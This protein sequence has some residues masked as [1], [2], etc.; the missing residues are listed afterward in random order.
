MK[1][2][3]YITNSHPQYIESLYRDFVKD[4]AGVDPDLRKF[5]EGFDFA[6]GQNGSSNGAA[7]VTA[8]KPVD[9]GQLQKE[10]AVY[11]LIQAYR[12][13]AHLIAKTNPIRPRKDRQANLDLKYFGLS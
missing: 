13:K 11:Q 12:K 4:P 7:T 8:G 1:D 9:S 2:F 5:F 10:L 3:S 6:V